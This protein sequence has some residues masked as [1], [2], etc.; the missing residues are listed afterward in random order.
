MQSTTGI[1]AWMNAFGTRNEGLLALGGFICAVLALGATLMALRDKNHW[2]AQLRDRRQW[3]VLL[4]DLSLIGR[5]PRYHNATMR[6]LRAGDQVFGPRLISW[7]TF[8]RCLRVEFI[9]PLLAALIGWMAFDI[10]SPGGVQIAPPEVPFA[11]RL[12]ATLGLTATGAA[13]ALVIYHQQRI[14]DAVHRRMT[15]IYER[16]TRRGGG[17]SELF[18]LC[19]WASVEYAPSALAGGLAVVV[20]AAVLVGAGAGSAIL[21]STAAFAA[22]SL[23]IG[24][25]IGA[26]MTALALIGLAYSGT[27]EAA[28]LI[29]LFALL[30]PL[31]NALADTLSVAATRY[32]L[33]K[34]TTGVQS[35]WQIAAEILLDLT[36][37]VGTLILLI[38]LIVQGL[39]IWAR[40]FPGSVPFDWRAYRAQILAGDRAAGMLLYGMAVTT[41]LPTLIHVSAGAGALFGLRPKL[42]HAARDR[43][44]D[45][46]ASLPDG[47][48]ITDPA[49]T[50]ALH[51]ID[52]LLRRAHGGGGVA[53]LLGSALVLGLAWAMIA[54]VL[55]F[56]PTPKV[57]P[58]A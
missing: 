41:L 7:Q 56:W 36:L 9:I 30:L 57:F 28:A 29:F 23:G 2:R 40:L 19:V 50:R 3:D 42:A 37:A 38:V 58:I 12:A 14:S 11:K 43:L 46:H 32:F 45:L 26:P 21:A 47:A 52:L 17:F 16:L 51:E 10:H 44:R 15:P 25:S 20:F 24:A 1:T 55:S 48:A 13:L 35:G 49:P 6:V 4:T 31:I 54:A 53:A 8:A 5:Q 33:R 34:I 27:K 22:F 39:E 18:R